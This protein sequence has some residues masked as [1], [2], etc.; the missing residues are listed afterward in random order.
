VAEE[1]SR[2][3]TVIVCEDHRLRARPDAE[4]VEEVGD[5]IADG[6]LAD[7]E[8]LRDLRVAEPLGHQRQHLP[9]ARRE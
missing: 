3:E 9:L 7:G 4:L 1:R 2:S 8:A 6:L 5:V